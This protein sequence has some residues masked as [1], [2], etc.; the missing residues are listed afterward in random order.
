MSTVALKIG[1]AIT[2]TVLLLFVCG[3]LAGNLLIYL[4]PAALNA[5]AKG[6]HDAGFLL[7]PVRIV[8]ACCLLVHISMAIVLANKNKKATGGYVKRTYVVAGFNS[9]SMLPTGIVIFFFILYH[10]AHLTLRITD[11]R[12]AQIGHTDVYQMLV[13]SFKSP[14][15]TFFY[16]LAMLFLGRHLHHGISSLF[17]TL[18]LN[19]RRYNKL[20]GG[21]GKALAWLIM[22]GNMSIPLSIYLGVI[23]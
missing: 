15:L 5:Y 4:G 12:F 14:V 18:G 8:L 7:W 6:L 11:E 3:H 21:G 17:Q 2:G 1:M 23:R 13:L 9:R 16:V 10:L 19:N 22:L 20:I